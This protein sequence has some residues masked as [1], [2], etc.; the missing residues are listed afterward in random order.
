LRFLSKSLIFKRFIHL[1]SN[2]ASDLARHAH[3]LHFQTHCFVKAFTHMPLFN[4]SR[5]SKPKQH[6]DLQY[7]ANYE[8]K[9][10][11]HFPSTPLKHHGQFEF[12]QTFLRE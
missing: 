12:T 10:L 11:C 9:H 2:L 6:T 8:T 1:A 4:E 7:V 5:I 3:L